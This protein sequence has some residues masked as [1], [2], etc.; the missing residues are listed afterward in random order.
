MFAKVVLLVALVSALVARSPTEAWYKQVAGPSYYPV[1]R[2]SGLLSGIRRWPYVRRAELE[3]TDGGESAGS[4]GAP[5][6]ENPQKHFMLKTMVSLP[7]PTLGA[8]LQGRTECWVRAPLRTKLVIIPT[9]A[10]LSAT[11]SSSGWVQ[12]FFL[13]SMCLHTR[14]GGKKCF[15]KND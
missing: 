6:E 8:L 10:T 4:D 7:P 2:A 3:P 12:D 14:T 11:D 9:R 15:W 1:G 13:V 5:T